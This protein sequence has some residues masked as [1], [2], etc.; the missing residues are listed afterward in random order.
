[1]FHVHAILE[2][3]LHGSSETSAKPS[4]ERADDRGKFSQQNE[5]TFFITQGSCPEF[6]E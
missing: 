4:C 3:S 5:P 6:N 1:M 2:E